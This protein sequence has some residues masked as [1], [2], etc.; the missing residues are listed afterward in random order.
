MALY[1]HLTGPRKEWINDLAWK[2]GLH[3]TVLHHMWKLRKFDGKGIKVTST[4]LLRVT[5]TKVLVVSQKTAA[6][7]LEPLSGLEQH[8]PMLGT[9]R[10]PTVLLWVLSVS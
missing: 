6:E 3:L 8:V 5:S 4:V 7:V 10:T 9:A 2:Y 1:M